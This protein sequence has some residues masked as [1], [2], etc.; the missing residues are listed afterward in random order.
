M[1]SQEETFHNYQQI[2][3]NTQAI[4][5]NNLVNFLHKKWKKF[6]MAKNRQAWKALFDIGEAKRGPA[7]ECIKWTL[8]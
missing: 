2:F 5:D 7:G 4:T 6:D 3:K 1:L 8:Y